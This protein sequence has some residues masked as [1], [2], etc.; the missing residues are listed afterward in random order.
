MSNSDDKTTV[1]NIFKKLRET[2]VRDP[3]NRSNSGNSG[4]GNP[5][6][7]GMTPPDLSGTFLENRFRIGNLS[8]A[9]SGEADVYHATDDSGQM[10]VVKLYRRSRALKEDVLLRLRNFSHPN[11]ASIVSYGSI[12][13]FGYTVIPFYP[14]VSLASVL[15]GGS[16]FSCDEI[17]ELILP[18]LATAVHAL[19]ELDILH[20]DIKPA[21]I[22]LSENGVRLIDFGISSDMDGKTV[23]QTKVGNSPLYAAPETFY[24]TCLKESDWYSVGITVY[25]LYAGSTP[26]QNQGL[27]QEELVRYAQA[28]RIP[29]PDDFPSDLKALIEGLT[30]RDLTRR[31]EAGNPNRRW[32]W[33]EVS[34]WLKGEKLPVPGRM[35]QG[36]DAPAGPQDFNVPY[37]Y[38]GRRIF[39]E[40]E[41]VE[42]LLSDWSF[43]IREISRGLLTRHFEVNQKERQSDIC[44]KCESDLEAKSANADS[45]YFK[46][47]YS[48][49]SSVTDLYWRGY[50]FKDPKDFGSRLVDEAQKGAGA[51]PEILAMA[52]S[53][54][55][56]NCL[57][58]YLQN[59]S[60]QDGDIYLKIV[61]A[62]VKQFDVIQSDSACHALR[63]GYAL[64]GRSDFT[65]AG[66]RYDTVAEF[67]DAMT[68]LRGENIVG[69]TD[70]I[71][72]NYAE[73][74]KCRNLFS[75]DNLRMFRQ[76]CPD[77]DKVISFDD[78]KLL[79][80]SPDDVLVYE[81]ELWKRNELLELYYFRKNNEQQYGSLVPQLILADDSA[82]R[83]NQNR[84]ENLIMLD[85][86]L[87]RTLSEFSDYW[88]SLKAVSQ[89]YADA[90]ISSVSDDLKKLYFGTELQHVKKMIE[91]KWL[92]AML[93]SKGD[94]KNF[95]NYYSDADKKQAV[96][97]IVLDVRG[98]KALLVS[99]YGIDA[100]P[101]HK[102]YTNI[103]WADC[104]LRKWLNQEFLQDAFTVDEQKMIAD[105][106]VENNSG[107][108]TK[109]KIFLL[110]VDEVKKYFNSNEERQTKATDY[111]IAQ[112][113]YV[114]DDGNC[115]WWLRSRG[116]NDYYPAYVY[117]DGNISG[118]GNS[119]DGTDASV[120]P[121]LWLNLKS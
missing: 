13:G 78:G 111:A 67:C 105:T 36:A 62:L 86:V 20:R 10:F 88:D 106:K 47:M 2:R 90:L 87:Y 39:S 43:G 42:T 48:L 84:Y 93:P 9:G 110:S 89:K 28:Q 72:R 121:A 81:N 5:S 32:G 119:V 61:D 33:N 51:D 21:N 17:R 31:D 26:Y 30:Y 82:R 50:L 115:W 96:E 94:I 8:T 95:G 15:A 1:L 40:K 6:T 27:S 29:F 107:S 69:L 24:G 113:A 22:I 102:D 16:R 92:Q 104:S 14:G 7:Q 41:L 53:L 76:F 54:L 85:G 70:F 83:R 18:S 73:L 120:R 55:K 46:C 19:H 74:L 59:D 75:G 116:G 34:R 109:D 97:W 99:R 80:V 65:V 77:R 112:G 35:P 58:F 3:D 11:L 71:S 38:K 66:R 56:N 60:V 37:L 57:R 4:D 117:R 100:K 91:S 63:L 23:V 12:K 45:I 52:E 108:Q 64:T 114:N 118:S 49:S 101:Y 79:F 25:E 44:R 68:K 103:T 98:D